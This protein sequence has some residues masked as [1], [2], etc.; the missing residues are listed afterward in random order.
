MKLI[1][2]NT[3]AGRVKEPFE[4]FLKS[5]APFTDIFCFQE[6][7]NDLD[8]SLETNIDEENRN[9]HIL[10]EITE[11]LPDF[12]VY[13]CPVIENVYGIAIFLK[14]EFEVVAS[15]EI[16]LYENPNF[17]SF[18]DTE[19]HDR[20]MQWVHIKKDRKDVIIMNVHGHWDAV[21]KKI[22][23]PN[24]IEQSQAII[25]FIVKTGS[26]PKILVGD[27]NLLPETES[28]KMIEQNFIN[29]ITK[30]NIPSTRTELYK[31]DLKHADYAF[32]SNEILVEKFEALPDVVSDHV[33]L[34][35]S[36]DVF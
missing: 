20:K 5:H 24:R 27:F 16:M 21:D 3:W 30:Y 10:K 6:I 23:T 13:F 35:L 32:V 8:E 29:L 33:P 19:D 7:Y 14:K 4:A 9:M 26:I 36:F 15:G 17:T 1:T 11:V 28:I 22:D 25:D 18:E 12:D 31:G 2:L 34:S